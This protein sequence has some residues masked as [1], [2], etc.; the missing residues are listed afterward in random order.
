MFILGVRRKTFIVSSMLPVDTTCFIVSGKNAYASIMTRNL[1][2]KLKLTNIEL[3][4]ID[5]SRLSYLS[6]N[7]LYYV[8]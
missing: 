5:Y 7:F 1:L 8:K 6:K 2:V 3:V 4:H